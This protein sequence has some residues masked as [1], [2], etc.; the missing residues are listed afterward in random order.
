VSA[1]IIRR[2]VANQRR[3]IIGWVLGMIG[4]VLMYGAFWPSIRDNADQFD[5]YLKTLPD[6]L[7]NAI[8]L[9][10]IGTPV[11]YL[12]TE[13]FTFLA[14]VLI[15]TFAIGAGAHAIAGEQED[16]TADLL[17]ATPVKRGRVVTEKWLAMLAGAGVIVASLWL[18]L[19]LIAPA[20]D[21]RVDLADAG[22][23]CLMVALL[24]LAF[25][26]IALLA[27]SWT[28]RKAWAIA[29]ATVLAVASLLID[30]LAP[31]VEGLGW[32]QRLS[33]FY[34]YDRSE[35]LANG[36]DATHA[37]I[38]LGVAVVALAAAVV[39]FDRRDVRA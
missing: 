31:S 25:G 15:L 3:A 23:A 37:L 26:S 8:G 6:F 16:E 27:G 36:L 11:G 22:A 28:G 9:Q 34:Y 2:T 29:V 24:G 1:V 18:C 30:V 17:L 7:R 19:A 5:E 21:L 39:V 38:M 12:K 33:L 32:L 13:L 4:M 14:P 20:F 10:E 35:P